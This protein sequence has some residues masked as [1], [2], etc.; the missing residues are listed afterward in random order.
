[1][2]PDARRRPRRPPPYVAASAA[3]AAALVVVALLLALLCGPCVVGARLIL[4]EKSGSAWAPRPRSSSPESTDGTDRRPGTRSGVLHRR[5]S[6]FLPPSGPSERH[7]ARLDSHAGRRGPTNPAPPPAGRPTSSRRP[8][9]RSAPT[10]GSTPT[11]A[12]VGRPTPPP[13]PPDVRLPPAVRPVGAPQR[14]APPRPPQRAPS[15]G[16]APPRRRRRSRHDDVSH[17]RIQELKLATVALY[18]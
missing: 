5:T 17:A 7:N 14:P 1:M 8:A 10:P 6:D 4:Q 15:S 18:S 12:G 3:R 16:P 13:P 2:A 11:P 9:R